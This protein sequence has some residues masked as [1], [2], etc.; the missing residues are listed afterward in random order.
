[1]KKVEI[2]NE[3]Y[4]QYILIIRVIDGNSQA[5]NFVPLYQLFSCHSLFIFQV[6]SLRQ[7][8]RQARICV[9]NKLVREA[10]RLRTSHGNETQ[11]EKNKNRADKL[12]RE[13]FA[14]KRIKDDEISKFGIV[15]YENLSNILQDPQSDDRIRAMAKIV[16][17]KS[18]S[19]RI[20]EFQEKHPDYRE[21][22]C[23]KKKKRSVK[24]KGSTIATF[25]EEYPKSLRNDII[26][27]K[28]SK[29]SMLDAVS[30]TRPACEKLKEINKECD[31][32]EELAMNRTPKEKL[33]DIGEEE[34]GHDADEQSPN[35]RA[36]E[37]VTKII[38][39]QASVK[40]FTEVLQE[41]ELNERDERNK[42]TNKGTN[43][44][45]GKLKSL[46]NV[47]DFF[48]HANDRISC[49]NDRPLLKERN[50]NNV[51]DN[52]FISVRIRSKK[53]KLYTEG[54]ERRDLKRWTS[55][56]KTIF[57]SHGGKKEMRSQH[58][59]EKRTYGRDEEKRSG[60]SE[61]VVKDESLHPSWAAKKKQQD[62]IK[63]GFQ[64][65]KIKFD[66]D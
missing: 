63:Q 3:V 17:Y 65:K 5:S 66:E 22:I 15:S 35:S 64:G 46:K 25:Q 18:L 23:W 34:I 8:V 12:L 6:V 14:L 60:G 24:K 28:K 32:L 4:F 62:I 52:T 9:I 44:P 27:S 59:E 47:D 50:V 54:G 38:S 20:I 36:S 7:S 16:R 31:K 11:V 39:T 33:S 19:S 43:S 55:N 37:T 29:G 42:G 51:D 56:N 53:S 58:W 1:M 10:K 26:E 30:T 2:N 40:R 49:S 13:V 21:R 41:T 48:V 61:K 57:Q 45:S